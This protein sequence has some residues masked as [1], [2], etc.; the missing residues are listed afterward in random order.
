MT[1]T[2]E[3]R[4]QTRLVLASTAG[5]AWTLLV[6][7]ILPRPSGM[8][9]HGAYRV[10]LESALALMVIGV[11]WE[12]AYHGLQQ[13]R[14]DR[15]WPSLIGLVTAVNEAVAV[16]V[17]LHALDVVP[18]PIGPQSAILVL[19]CVHFVGMWLIIWLLAQGPVRVISVRWRLEGGS[20]SGR[21]PVYVLPFVITNVGTV[22]VLAGIWLAW[23]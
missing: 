22:L 11:V 23:R 6:T 15:D 16:W 12:L 13:L 20:F 8:S 7:P 19:F 2:L 18:G 1:P 14:W 9:V 3:G 5:V 10:T 21:P 4:I 17:V